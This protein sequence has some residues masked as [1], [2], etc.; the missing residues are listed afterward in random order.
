MHDRVKRER[1]VRAG[2]EGEV[3]RWAIHLNKCSEVLGF[4]SFGVLRFLSHGY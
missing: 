4:W 3:Y 1:I 2:R